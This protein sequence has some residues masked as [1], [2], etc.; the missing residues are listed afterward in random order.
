MNASLD[1]NV[2]IHL[3]KADM[4]E[5]LFD[6]FETLKIYEF[7]RTHELKRQAEPEILQLFDQD[8][9]K[10]RIEMITKEYIKNIGMIKVFDSHVSDLKI[11]FDGSDLGEIY[12]IALAKILG[13]MYL[14]TDDIKERGPHYTL[15]REIESDVMPFAFYEILYLDY[16]DGKFNEEELVGHFNLICDSSD[17]TF[18]CESKLKSFIRRFCTSPYDNEEKDWF[19]EYCNHNNINAKRKFKSLER[20]LKTIQDE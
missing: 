17:L 19:K 9:E 14:I 1:T 6:R 3:Y 13:C 12:A 8:L 4:Q 20:Y 18:D 5:I 7:I 2:I 11:I 16:L 10:R 15:M